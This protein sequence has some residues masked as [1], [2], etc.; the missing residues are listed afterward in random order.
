MSGCQPEET[1]EYIGCSD[2]KCLSV[3][4]NQLKKR[5]EKLENLVSNLSHKNDV[6]KLSQEDKKI[7]QNCNNTGLFISK[8]IIPEADLRYFCIFTCN[9][10]EIGTNVRQHTMMHIQNS[11]PCDC[12]YRYIYNYWKGK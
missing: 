3:C 12:E 7:C 1:F 8:T 2:P 5:I 4:C 10:C 11:E 9:D 6:A